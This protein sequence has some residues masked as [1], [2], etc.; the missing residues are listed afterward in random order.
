MIFSVKDK[1]ACF[2]NNKEEKQELINIF[3]KNFCFL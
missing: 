1:K 2:Y 3:N